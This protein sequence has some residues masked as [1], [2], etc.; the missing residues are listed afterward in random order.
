MDEMIRSGGDRTATLLATVDVVG[1]EM[2]PEDVLRG[3]QIFYF[4]GDKRMSRDGYIACASCHLDGAQ[5]G[6]VW[7]RTARGRGAAQHHRPAHAAGK[8]HWSANF[9][10]VRISSRTSGCSS[11][12]TDFWTTTPGTMRPCAAEPGQSRPQPGTGCAGRL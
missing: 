5:D 10:E 3:K 9:D 11:A 4:A 8:L 1:H 6:R 2:V 12:A 7:D